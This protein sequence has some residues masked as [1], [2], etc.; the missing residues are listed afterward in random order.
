M[1]THHVTYRGTF[2]GGDPRDFVP[3]PD[4]STPEQMENHRAFCNI[5]RAAEAAG[6]AIEVESAQ[7]ESPE[8]SMFGVGYQD[9]FKY[10]TEDSI[11]DQ[12]LE[13]NR[14]INRGFSPRTETNGPAAKRAVFSADVLEFWKKMTN[15][16]KT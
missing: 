3:D 6:E 2:R 7:L 15:A 14:A 4:G 12:I 10:E 11:L 13:Q 16:C 8:N 5:W 1:K 9:T